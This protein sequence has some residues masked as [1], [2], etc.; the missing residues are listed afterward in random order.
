[1]GPE[2]PNGCEVVRRTR[3]APS[4]SEGLMM[5]RRRSAVSGV[6]NMDGGVSEGRA[7]RVRFESDDESPGKE[8]VGSQCAG[9]QCCDRYGAAMTPEPE[10][11]VEG[12]PL[13]SPLRLDT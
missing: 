7:R 10:T 4:L 5:R 3:S 2:C 11:S 12:M 8:S 1:M 9:Y 6:A 13:P